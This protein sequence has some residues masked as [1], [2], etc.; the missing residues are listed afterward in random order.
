MLDDRD[1]DAERAAGALAPP[2]RVRIDPVRPPVAHRAGTAPRCGRLRAS[3]GRRA[4]LRPRRM[5]R[6]AGPVRER[7][8]LGV[9]QVHGDRLVTSEADGL[10]PGIDDER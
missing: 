4:A 2:S 3:A 6:S 7:L 8:A 10:L 1:R 9:L 5:P